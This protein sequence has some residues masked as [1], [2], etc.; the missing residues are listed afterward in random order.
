MS[1]PIRLNEY[2]PKWVE[3]F[4]KECKLLQDNIGKY[5]LRID[6]IGSTSIVG[7]IAKPIIDILIGVRNIQDAEK[8]IPILEKLGY[9][10]VPD[11]EDELPERRY[12]RK[13][14]IGFRKFHIHMAEI[15]SYFWKRQ[16][17]FRDYLRA[18]SDKC[19]EYALL[20]KQLATKF[21]NNRSLYTDSKSDFINSILDLAEFE[22]K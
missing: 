19:K 15:S 1:H 2:N 10:Y 14:K 12:F 17:F 11:F 9:Q 5:I 6:H 16:I 4:E 20:K 3:I 21:K 8:C 7:L 13:P 22:D 18:H